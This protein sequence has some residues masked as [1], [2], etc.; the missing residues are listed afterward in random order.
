MTN[1]TTTNTMNT[2]NT[3]EKNA[4]LKRKLA[5]AMK[6]Q[7]GSLGRGKSFRNQCLAEEYRATLEALGVTIPN[8]WELLELGTFNGRGS[9]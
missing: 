3:E 4:V 9:C 8:Q 2:M 5:N 6:T 1:T 7:Y